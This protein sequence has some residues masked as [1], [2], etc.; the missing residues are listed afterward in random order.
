MS[1]VKTH[2]ALNVTD[3]EKS[4][5]FYRAMFGV[6][7]VKHKPDYAKFD[8]ENPALNFT[9]NLTEKV[10]SHGALSHLGIQV[11]ST[12]EV[13]AAI[14][15]F[16]Q[17]GLSLFEE[18][19]TNCCY[20]LQDKV[21]VSDPDGNRWEIFVVKVGDTAPEQNVGA[22]AAVEMKDKKPCCA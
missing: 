13:K 20:A 4:V 12:A 10:Q 7:P 5:A 9:L 21:W 11:N 8:L 19:N 17:A 3:I 2:V 14:E 15:R 1:A 6:T 16:A 18:Q 22:V